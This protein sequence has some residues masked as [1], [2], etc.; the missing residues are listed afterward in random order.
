MRIALC[1]NGT[2]ERL[3]IAIYDCNGLHVR[4]FIL[5]ELYSFLEPRVQNVAME[6]QH[7]EVLRQDLGAA[8]PQVGK[9]K[10]DGRAEAERRAA[11]ALFRPVVQLQSGG[12]CP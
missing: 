1:Y 6:S 11:A 9:V 2:L 4:A 12:G 10:E 3:T 7:P 8:Q 5:F